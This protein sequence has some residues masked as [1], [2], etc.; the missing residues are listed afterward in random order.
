M[1]IEEQYGTIYIHVLKDNYLKP[2]KND[3]FEAYLIK[4][5]MKYSKN[6]Y[7]LLREYDDLAN[8][9]ELT[10]SILFNENMEKDDKIK[11]LENDRKNK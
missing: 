11:K 1:N 7:E 5:I 4:K 9:F 3:K 8:D 2:N 10:I 6:E